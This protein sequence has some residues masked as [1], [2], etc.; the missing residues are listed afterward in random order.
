[1]LGVVF[2]GR[3]QVGNTGIRGPVAG[4]G[5]GSRRNEVVRTVRQRLAPLSLIHRGTWTARRSHQR[6]RA[7]RRRRRS[8]RG[9]AKC[10]RRRPRDGAPLQRLPAMRILPDGL[11]AALPNRIPEG[12]WFRRARR[13]RRLRTHRRLHVR[14]YAGRPELRRGSGDSMRHRHGVS[15][16]A[17]AGCVRA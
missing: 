5:A 13:Q 4:C 16:A 17:P 1:M 6:P 7:L 14:A 3:K 11:D 8:R 15:G 10:A 9:R 12:L 2:T